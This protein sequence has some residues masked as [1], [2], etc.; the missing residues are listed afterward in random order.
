[1]KT[2]SAGAQLVLATSLALF[3]PRLAAQE[4][5]EGAL[6]RANL[7]A[8][9]AETLA[10]AD[11]DNDNKVDG[12]VLLDSGG[13]HRQDT[14]LRIELHLSGRADADLTFDSTEAAHAVGARDIDQDGD[15]DVIVEQPFTQQPLQVWL[16]DGR[17]GFRKGRIEELPSASVPTHQRLKPHPD[18]RD[19]PALCL[20][21]KRGFQVAML[22]AR[23]MLSRRSA[24]GRSDVLPITSSPAARAFAHDA[25][26][27]PPFPR[28]N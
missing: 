1:M 24:P 13:L 8:P 4:G 17:G 11:L 27:A 14:P 19:H 5:L 9:F 25:S 2:Q 22:T 10:V 23:H 12:A 28:S 16:N 18:L 15:T 21:L 26:R 20:P 7:A 3:A 6:A